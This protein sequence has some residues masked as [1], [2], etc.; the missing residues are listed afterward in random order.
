[1]SRAPSGSNS[2]KLNVAGIIVVCACRCA[3]QTCCTARKIRKVLRVT[4]VRFDEG[5]DLV[6]LTAE[7]VAKGLHFHVS[8]LAPHLA[9]GSGQTAPAR[10]GV[11][12]LRRRSTSRPGRISR[13]DAD[14]LARGT[15]GRGRCECTRFA[16]AR[17]VVRTL[18]GNAARGV[19][20]IR[21][22]GNLRA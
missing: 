4:A 2:I 17:R 21:S 12:G 15:A 8:H 13:S 18:F 14:A 3:D 16:V 20:A 10:N 11:H 1:M 7:N 5:H 9:N 6:S 19:D 22:N